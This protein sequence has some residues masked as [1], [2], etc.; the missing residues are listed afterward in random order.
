VL[1]PDIREGLERRAAPPTTERRRVAAASSIVT[2]ASL[3][4]QAAGNAYAEGKDA[5]AAKFREA[6]AK[7][8][9]IAAD[10]PALP[11]ATR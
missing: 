5:D 6:A 8:D 7:L 3:Y 10:L 11:A 4:R 9:A 2:L 1:D